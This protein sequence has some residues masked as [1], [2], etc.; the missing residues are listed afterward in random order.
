[1]CVVE[2]PALPQDLQTAPCL[3][4]AC[5]SVLALQQHEAN[6]SSLETEGSRLVF[7]MRRRNK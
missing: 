3:S 4:G 5:A 1:M 6:Y 7:G 2:Q